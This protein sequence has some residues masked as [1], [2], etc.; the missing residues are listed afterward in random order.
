MKT[1]SLLSAILFACSIALTAPPPAVAQGD[2]VDGAIC[3]VPWDRYNCAPL[4]VLVDCSV[5]TVTPQAP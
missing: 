1:R 4:G 2:C 5:C 3:P